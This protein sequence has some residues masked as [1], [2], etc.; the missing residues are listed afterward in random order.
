VEINQVIGLLE[1]EGEEE[2]Y[3][4]R[5]SDVGGSDPDE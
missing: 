2:E 3:I 4:Y 5:G 1:G